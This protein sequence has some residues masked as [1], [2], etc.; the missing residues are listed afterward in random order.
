MTAVIGRVTQG[1]D[2]RPETR[3][4]NLMATMSPSVIDIRTIRAREV[5]GSF[6]AAFDAL[7]PS[8]SLVVLGG[9]DLGDLLRRLQADR[10]GTFEWFP[11]GSGSSGFRVQVTR[12]AAEPGAQREITEALAAD[13]DRLDAL[14]EQAFRHFAAN[15]VTRAQGAWAE[16]SFGLLRHIR[17]EEEILF[18][19][20]EEKTGFAPTHG[21]TGV[22]RGEHREIERLVDAIGRAFTGDGTALRLRNELHRV[23]GE[24]NM[25]EE[26]MLYPGTDQCLGP[27]ERDAL[28][29][30]IQ[31][32]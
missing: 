4:E 32:S 16:F 13:H 7:A 24:H 9:A 5:D 28:V 29:A 2:D 30:R 1:G 10:K 27:A 3:K 17:F 26:R 6:L 19:A 11:L 25:K 31:A 8:E 21:P 18:P 14:E 12:R 22:M 23:L 20:F 15:D